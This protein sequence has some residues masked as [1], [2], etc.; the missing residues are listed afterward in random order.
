[1][2]KRLDLWHVAWGL[3]GILA[4]S[5]VTLLLNP[6]P[7]QVTPDPNS[8]DPGGAS[9][10]AELLT[11]A[12]Y[13]VSVDHHLRPILAPGD[14]A[15]CFLY[16]APPDADA[17]ASAANSPLA[18]PDETVT[19]A[20]TAVNAWNDAGGAALWLPVPKEIGTKST[21]Q[22]TGFPGSRGPLR[23]VTTGLAPT[24]GIGDAT[25]I[26]DVGTTTDKKPAAQLGKLGKGYELQPYN[27]YMALNDAIGQGDNARMLLQML[28][29]LGGPGSH[30]VVFTTATY[31]DGVPIT[32]MEAIGP[33][34]M[35]AWRQFLLLLVVIVV[36]LGCR[37]GLPDEEP[38]RKEQGGYELING[39]A[40]LLERARAYD[41]ALRVSLRRAEYLIRRRLKLGKDAPIDAYLE[42]LPTDVRDSLDQ[43]R[44][45]LGSNAPH[46]YVLRSVRKLDQAVSDFAGAAKHRA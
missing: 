30:R 22:V 39:L 4:I 23:L 13:R 25:G 19:E 7:T 18:P 27:G 20:V 34:A 15:V 41:R 8:Y 43:M 3:V 16:D 42:S 12:G 10:F 46:A 44:L 33:W 5:M 40:G 24:Q 6:K 21:V 36:T 17:A 32:L 26:S 2:R 31:G 38:R 29:M 28:S 37:F 9:A 14:I 45:L 1:M 35:A 11:R